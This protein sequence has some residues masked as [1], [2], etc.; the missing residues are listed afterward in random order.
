MQAAEFAS[1]LS[2]LSVL[3]VPRPNGS[4]TLERTVGAVRAWLE[5]EGIP[6]QLHRFTLH[7][8]FMELLGLWL[9]LTGFLLPA[10]ALGRW[11]WGGLILA[12]VTLAVLRRG[13]PAA[14]LGSFDLD[15]GG[16]GFH[17][18]LDNPSRVDPDRLV[19]TMTVLSRFLAEVDSATTVRLS[20]AGYAID[21]CA[22]V[23]RPPVRV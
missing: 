13:I 20:G 12:L 15:L 2:H 16:R 6:V 14:T 17:S 11:G 22:D 4:R 9:A 10:A 7:P 8:Y 3:S 23:P 18:A 1:L 21:P 5:K 19:E